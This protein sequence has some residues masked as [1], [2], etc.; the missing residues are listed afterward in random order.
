M[1]NS[2]YGIT[3]QDIQIA[4]DKM[5]NQKDYLSSNVITTN[6]GQNKSFLDMSFSANLSKRYYAEVTNRS[7]T[8]HSLALDSGHKP[9]FL[10]ITLNGC[11]RDS[12]KGDFSRFTAK[13]LKNIPSEVKYKIDNNVVLTIRDLVAVLNKQW[14]TYMHRAPFKN[15]RKLKQKYNYIRA[16]EPHKKDGVPHIHALLYIPA[17]SMFQALESF[18]NVFYAPQNIKNNQLSIEQKQNGEIN[19]FQWTLNNPTGYVMKYIQ[20]TFVN[21]DKNEDLDELATWYIKHKVRRFL[22]SRSTIPLW[23]YRKIFFME[24]DLFTLSTLLKDED[25]ICEWD[26]ESKYIRLSFPQIQKEIEYYNGH[27]S[28]KVAGREII[29][30]KSIESK[31]VLENPTIRKKPFLPAFTPVIDTDNNKLG[32]TN[33][34][35]FTKELKKQPYQ[36][37]DYELFTHFNDLDLDDINI[38]PH[39]VANC[40]NELAKRGFYNFEKVQMSYYEI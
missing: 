33:G 7:N 9:I 24:K 29:K 18:K 27:Y 3:K 5:Q 8:I 20:K 15:L 4:F 2:P 35:I 40:H 13:E 16:F 12:L 32:F 25:S 39:Y 23:V 10:T 1:K 36:M 6:T 14:I 11:W 34:V 17:S 30:R 21:V 37:S 28:L 19:G 38:N 31:R 26:F 22:T